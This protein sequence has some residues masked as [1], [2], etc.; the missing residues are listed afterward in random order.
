MSIKNWLIIFFAYGTIALGAWTSSQLRS[1]F[2]LTTLNAEDSEIYQNYQEYSKK[3]PSEDN[4]LIVSIK[5]EAGFNSH[6]GFSTLEELRQELNHFHGVESAVG[7]TSVELPERTLLG[8][9]S[10]KLMPI[11]G[12]ASKKFSDRYERLEKFPDVTPK[13]LSDDRMAAR[14][15]L[16]VDWNEVKLDQIQRKVESYAFDEVHLM[17][18][19]V[20]AAEMQE[21]L[22]SE[23]VL[24]PLFAGGIL[25]FFFLV[26]FKDVRSLILVASILAINLSLLSI[27]F[28][29]GGI[30]IGLLTSTT[31]LLILVLS[32][33][34]IVHMIYKF[35]QLK[36]GSIEDRVKA[37]VL[38]LRLPLWL[39]TLTTGVAFALFFLTEIKEITEFAAVT[40]SGVV[41]AYLTARFLLPVF[42]QSFRI[43][44]FENA[45]AFSSLS[46]ALMRLLS[47]RKVTVAIGTGVVLIA[48]VS[49]WFNFSINIS[50]HQNY[51][52]DTRLGQALR[53][54]DD[55]FEGV[56]SVEV[57]LISKNGL[58]QETVSKIDQIETQ[59][60][61]YYGCKSVFSVNTAIKRLHRFKRFGKPSQYK[62]PEKLDRSFQRDLVKYRDD[63]GLANAMTQDQQ[64]FRIVGRLP[65]IGSAV[66]AVKNEELQETLDRLE[67]DNHHFFIS[68][69]SFVKDQS[70]TRVTKFILIGISISLIIAMI[71]IGLVFRS[72][73]IALLSFIPNLLPVLFGLALMY[74][75][76]IE[77]NPTTAMAL[78]IIF[79]LAL[80]D[81]IYFLSSIKRLEKLNSP[82]SIELSLRENTF[83]AAVTSIILMIGFGILMFS[84]IESNRNIGILVA[85][86][87]FIAL[88]SDLVL[89]PALLRS[90]WNK[91]RI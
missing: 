35:K 59:L 46:Q 75:F 91:R 26:W 32:F 79:G 61:E 14:I 57:I 64:L 73:R 9:T 50:Y 67:D 19:G 44:P 29:V 72:A 70:N 41:L 55:Y 45:A 10:K 51:G 54:S 52:E 4:G 17:G 63:L 21:S 1:D 90:F 71:V 38:P 76:H 39:T 15:F 60:K 53:F 40:C 47:G 80:D 23:M 66:S 28:Y 36:T 77:L 20:Y 43:R 25:L 42:I 37:T 69:F 5:S 7:I 82:E 83:P 30:T 22:T 56:R 81:T 58:T 24:L 62:L 6:E 33:S 34:D 65:D 2:S 18:K 3:F 8:S 74:W 87:L 78:S 11:D 84:S 85:S 89:L 86:M 12:E 48:A 13:F 27:V 16:T 68:G 49:V 88:L 31:P